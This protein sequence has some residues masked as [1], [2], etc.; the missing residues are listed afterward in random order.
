VSPLSASNFKR[1]IHLVL[2]LA[3]TLTAAPAAADG[4]QSFV[5]WYVDSLGG[6]ND[7]TALRREEK[8]IVKAK[9]ARSFL[10]QLEQLTGPLRPR[11]AAPAGSVN[12]TSTDYLNTGKLL[13]NLL[14]LAAIPEGSISPKIRVRK[15]LH[16]DGEDKVRASAITDGISALELKMPHP[17]RPGVSLK[18]RLFVN[19]RH[20]KL[21]LNG[22][23]FAE[24]TTR[25][26]VVATLK[27]DAR[28]DSQT[29]DRF[30]Q[31]FGQLHQRSRSKKLS[32][33]VNTSYQRTAYQIPLKA[34]NIQVTVDAEVRYNHPRSGKTIRRMKRSWRAVEVKIPDAYAAMT[35]QELQAKG[36]GLVAQERQLK[37]NVLEANQLSRF[38]INKGKCSAFSRLAPKRSRQLKGRARWRAPR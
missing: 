5:A 34:G 18:P 24:P 9:Y 28:N 2:A 14:G 33:W 19:N 21:M 6:Q 31:L 22:K 26:A 17:T 3:L 13:P 20:L 27:A 25:A 38:G 8:A 15:Y 12:L 1:S 37:R 29:V 11:D 35:D 16:R 36:L 32:P 23:R 7:T 30:V 10:R 4:Q